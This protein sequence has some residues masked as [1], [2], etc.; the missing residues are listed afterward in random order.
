M[1]FWVIVHS[2]AEGFYFV[3]ERFV[4]GHAGL[5]NF[6]QLIDRVLADD[7]LLEGLKKVE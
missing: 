7:W 4:L 6:P 5:L 3:R 1:L 2:M